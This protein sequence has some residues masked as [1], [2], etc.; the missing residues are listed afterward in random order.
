M[1]DKQI[2]RGNEFWQDVVERGLEL[3]KRELSSVAP[4]A[5]LAARLAVRTAELPARPAASPALP[6]AFSSSRGRLA[7][8]A[9]LLLLAALPWLWRAAHST[10]APNTAETAVASRQSTHSAAAP[11]VPA[12]RAI[13]PAASR[14]SSLARRR[15]RLPDAR[16]AR[17]QAEPAKANPPSLPVLAIFPTPLPASPASVFPTPTPATRQEIMLARLLASHPSP[18]VLAALKPPP[19]PSWAKTTR[20]GSDLNPAETATTRSNQR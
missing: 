6:A 10:P 9:A 13:Q 7:A 14:R 5:S 17:R 4:P 19:P 2:H 11:V 1:R 18:A 8:V 16:L 3:E 15:H 20:E 12:P